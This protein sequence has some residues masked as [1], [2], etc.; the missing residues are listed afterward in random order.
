MA[1][2]AGYAATE[3]AHQIHPFVV[4][5]LNLHYPKRLWCRTR[6]K[7]R[8]QTLHYYLSFQQPTRHIFEVKLHIAKPDPQGQVLWMPNW[9]PGSYMIRDFSRHITKLTARASEQELV[10]EKLAKNRWRCP[11]VSM[12]LEI[13][14]LIYAWDMSVRGAHFD[15]NHAYFNGA[16]LFLAVQGYENLPHCLYLERPQAAWGQGW[17][18]ATSLPD[19]LVDAAGFGRYEA[20]HY[21]DLIDHPVEV[22]RFNR[23]S[24]DV[25]GCKHAL[26]VSGAGDFNAERLISDVQRICTA[27]IRFFKDAP[28]FLHYVFLL[29]MVDSGYGGLEHASSC[30]LLATRECLPGRDEPQEPSDAY[31]QLLGLI[32][33]EYFH[34]WNVKR[35]RPAVFEPYALEHEVHTP[36]L[37]FFEGVTSYYDDLFLLRAG[38]ISRQ[39]YGCLLGQ[40]ITRYLRQPGWQWQ[41]LVDASFDAWTKYYRQDENSLNVQTSYY[42]QGSLVAL[43]L[44]LYLL[45]QSRQSL[46]LDNLMLWLWR[47]YGVVG[48][49][50]AMA[51]VMQALCYLQRGSEDF[52]K[53]MVTQCQPLPLD[54]LLTRQGMKYSRRVR[55]SRQDMG[56]VPGTSS[57]LNVSLGGQW[58]AREGGLSLTHVYY[59]GALEQAGL[60][61]GDFIMAIQGRRATES[62]CEAILR[63]CRVGE[64]LVIH[65]FRRDEL[66]VVDVILQES[67]MDTC[68]LT[69]SHDKKFEGRLRAWLGDQPANA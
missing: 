34:A 60:S 16:A 54:E 11:P 49:G 40:Q 59:D 62:V 3:E 35:L 30:S 4:R 53:T 48:R 12:A 65:A 28:P 9:I 10:V 52:L 61:V 38:C 63:G 37:W 20:S 22:G 6:Q 68:Y 21:A 58:Q 44:N 57:G 5:K 33:H 32:S 15:L 19:V 56:G 41:S 69:R 31:T 36:L 29:Q 39:H 42:V 1:I 25:L 47:T 67:S 23:L 24:F 43:C 7:A 46:S 64:A 51:D 27:Q 2:L 50:I 18:V 17:Q 26:V 55:E 13:T 45:Q 8:M 66:M 14:Y